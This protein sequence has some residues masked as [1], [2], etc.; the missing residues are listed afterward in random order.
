MDPNNQGPGKLVSTT[1]LPPTTPTLSGPSDNS[2]F[3]SDAQQKAITDAGKSL[4]AGGQAR[5][6]QQT[7]QGTDQ[8]NMIFHG[9]SGALPNQQAS[10]PAP[11]AIPQV[12]PPPMV[13]VPT[14]AVSD[15]RAKTKVRE[16]NDKTRAF[17][18]AIRNGRF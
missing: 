3:L 15:Q 16:A 9:T 1:A 18:D 10:G 8:F 6:G 5:I 4:M 12:A 11:I 13:Q 7:H 2:K 17:L 14:A